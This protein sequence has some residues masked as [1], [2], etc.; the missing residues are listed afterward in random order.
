[1][2]NVIDFFTRKTH[3]F[4]TFTQ[5]FMENEAHL[6]KKKKTQWDM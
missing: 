1:M 3:R 5:L 6:K 4:Q 2:E